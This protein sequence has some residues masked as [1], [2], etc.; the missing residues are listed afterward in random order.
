EIQNYIKKLPQDLQSVGQE[1]AAAIESKFAELEQSVENKQNELID[2]LAQKYQENLQAVDTRIDEMKA[3][4]KGLIQKAL[5]AVVGVVKTI[6]E[7]TKMLI[8][9]LARAASVVG[10]IIKDPIGFLSNLVSAVKQGFLNFMKDIGKHLQN[11]LIGW[12]TGTMAEAGIQMPENFDLKGIFSIA[13]QLLGFTYEAI[14]AQAVKRLGEDGEEKV[15][16]MEQTVEVFQILATQ[17]VAG[18]WQFVQEKM[19]DLNALI[20]EPIKNFIVEKVITAGIEWVLSLLT[21]ASAF[22]KACQGIYNIVKFFIERAQQIADLINAILDSIVAIASGSLDQAIKGVENALA[23][24]LPVVISFLASLLGLGGISQKIQGIIQKL[25]KP[26]EKAVDW[27]IDK[28][29]KAFGKVSNK[30]NNSKVG[31]KFNAAKDAAVEKYKAGKQWVEDK[32]AAGEKW[33]DDKKQALLDATEKRKAQFANTKAGKAL[34]S[35]NDGLGKKLDALDKKRQAFNNKI[36]AAKEWPS[37]QLEKV[38]DKAAELRGK[39]G[40][41]IKNSKFGKSVGK[42]LDKTKD[43]V[44][45]KKD[46]LGNKLGFGKDKEKDQDSKEAQKDKQNTNKNPNSASDKKPV[47]IPFAMNGEQHTLFLTL[48]K[49]P[50]LEMASKRDRLSNKIGR[51]IAKLQAQPSKTADQIKQIEALKQIGKTAKL[52]QIDQVKKQTPELQNKIEEQSTKLTITLSNYAIKYGVNDIEQILA[53]TGDD[54]KGLLAAYRGIHF[55]ATWDE[56]KYENEVK[57]QANAIIGQPEFSQATYEVAKNLLGKDTFTVEELESAAETVRQQVEQ[58]KQV[59]ANEL[60]DNPKQEIQ[61]GTSLEDLRSNAQQQAYHRLKN[62]GIE[63]PTQEQL[64]QEIEAILMKPIQ[65]GSN[66]K[67]TL[68]GFENMFYVSIH[69]YVND[70]KQF[71]QEL[72]NLKNGRYTGLK[73]TKIPFIS[74][75][76]VAQEAAKYAFGKAQDQKDVREEGVVGRI[77]IYLFS[78]KE[79]VKQGT[80]NIEKLHKENKI[81]RREWNKGEAEVTFTGSIPGENLVGYHNADISQTPEV[82]G[83]QAEQ[84][85]KDKAA[86]MGGLYQWDT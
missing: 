26:M 80:L 1:A 81:S 13:M 57:K 45:K 71:L 70:K 83:S 39:A 35:A 5:D 9:V 40:E 47:E 54:K 72:S 68:K 74:T 63:E 61:Q 8:E 53:I 24:S 58:L 25:R 86:N 62:K 51:A 21:P 33:F 55:K 56:Q 85:A 77:F 19:G 52:I 7:L 20:V 75:S 37:K 12:L 66:K 34:N 15:S 65:R 11:G 28:G 3:A 42:T 50:S 84:T 22:I 36:E 38:Q 17:G 29:K 82:L 10:E 30:F 76:K 4:N 6:I 46:A 2:T 78:I 23:K 79:E 73:F 67:A 49:K 43:V 16:R 31:K 14:R 60:K 41:K 64:N 32:K 18:I 27:V 44:G 69:Q 59:K 48:G